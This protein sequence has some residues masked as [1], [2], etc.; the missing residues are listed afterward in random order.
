MLSLCQKHLEH[1]HDHFEKLEPY[2]VR[3][4]A[5]AILH[6][7]EQLQALGLS[8]Y[9]EALKFENASIKC[10]ASEIIPLS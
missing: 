8:D 9:S 10:L 3:A 7:Y 2:F 1:G 5:D 4:F 6:D